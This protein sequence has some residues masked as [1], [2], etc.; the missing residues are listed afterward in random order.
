MN[1]SIIFK[2]EISRIFKAKSTL[3]AILLSAL[4]PL[5]VFIPVKYSITFLQIYSD[6]L[7]ST[8]IL[9]PAKLAAV[10][11]GLIFC[12]LTVFEFNRIS[13]NNISELIEPIIDIKILNLY[14]T[15][16][17]IFAG[18]VSAVLS[19]LVMLPYTIFNMHLVSDYFLHFVPYSLIVF[20]S[21]VMCVLLTAGIYMIVKRVDLTMLFM[22]F[23][24]AIN[25]K[26]WSHYL[27]HWLVGAECG[28]SSDYGSQPSIDLDLIN[29][30]FW[31]AIALAVYLIGYLSTRI[32]NK[33]M[34]K[35]F[36]INSK[37][38]KFIAP[39]FI[40]ALISGCVF[41]G[42]FEPIND[43][44]EYGWEQI[45]KNENLFLQKGII[46]LSVDVKRKSISETCSYY[47]DN[48]SD[49]E[50]LATLT[51]TPGIKIK[52]LKLG[53]KDL[54]FKDLNRELEGEHIFEIKLPAGKNMKLDIVCAG[55]PK[56]W[57]AA[58]GT[59]FMYLFSKDYIGMNRRSMPCLYISRDKNNLETFSG[60]I[61]IPKGLTLVTDGKTN[62]K[63]SEDNNLATW[64]FVCGSRPDIHC[65][66]Y[67]CLTIPADDTQVEIYYHENQEKHVAEYKDAIKNIN[68]YFSSK[69]KKLD[70]KGVPF[71]F[72][73]TSACLQSGG[74]NAGFAYSVFDET[75]FDPELIEKNGSREGKSNLLNTFVHEMCH[76]WNSEC[77]EYLDAHYKKQYEMMG[78]DTSNIVDKWSSEGPT[79]YWTYRYLKENVD[80]ASAEKQID[81]WKNGVNQLK[82][83]FYF[84]NPKWLDILPEKYS[85]QIR[86]GEQDIKL[87]KWTPL[88]I[89][90]A[91]KILGTEKFDQVFK[92]IFEDNAYTGK[93]L[94]YQDFLKYLNLT[95]E[96]I[97]VE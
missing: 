47:V 95:E 88:E 21:I 34:F 31:I 37:K 32:Y 79:V 4:S 40:S 77:V 85:A 16:G 13:R 44:S 61:T 29:R 8:T 53:G 55:K 6:T 90:N 81:D 59:Y 65:A 57:R 69:F 71:K 5:L 19:C 86:T 33:N 82:R 91:E 89:L 48:L 27:C 94:T 62:E 68:R 24:I 45:E 15:I 66:K 42:I 43:H 36:W 72:V 60:T 80:A 17:L 14:K 74:G 1:R 64:N 97:K 46:D 56:Q 9:W 51:I 75:A 18:V 2:N 39:I 78:I 58:Y 10:A 54:E 35:S 73:P 22:F 23:R 87:Y 20:P 63:I 26:K 83:N 7:A 49:K 11:S 84:R 67:N 25:F 3:L 96:A 12:V 38:T 28:Y 41:F 30:P 50:E 76:Q 70:L 93:F 52:S 92:K